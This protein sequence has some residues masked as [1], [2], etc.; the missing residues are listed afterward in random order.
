[1]IL[2]WLWVFI[3]F[4]ALIL[5]YMLFAPFYLEINSIKGLAQIR[6]HRLISAT[7][8]LSTSA[9]IELRIAG[10]MKVID[11]F[12][13]G[14]QQR[15][16][17]KKKEKN[18]KKYTIS[19]YRIRAIVASFKVNKCCLNIDTGNNELNG[20]LYPAFFVLGKYIKKPISINFAGKNEV[21]IEI[22][23]NMAR[24]IRTFIVSSYKTKNYGKLK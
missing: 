2:I 21:I 3:L 1:M 16:R 5:S 8:V 17:S 19:V 24:I 10:W 7:L 23:N 12:E 22:E 6:L 14:K 13:L 20:V 15:T 18:K 11:L 9:K 4:I